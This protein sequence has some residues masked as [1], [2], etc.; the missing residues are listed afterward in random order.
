MCGLS[1]AM[2][3]LDH[4]LRR[5]TIL[6]GVYGPHCCYIVP[7]HRFVVLLLYCSA[8]LSL[9]VLSVSSL[10]PPAPLFTNRGSSQ[11][12]ARVAKLIGIA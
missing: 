11:S 6:I 8:T 5:P 4:S 7:L 12:T 2:K 10:C 1:S 9:Y 3:H